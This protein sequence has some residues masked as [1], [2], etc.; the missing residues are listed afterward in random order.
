MANPIQSRNAAQKNAEH[1]FR[2]AEEQPDTSGIRMRTRKRA[3]TVTIACELR[4]LRLAKAT[5][6]AV[7]DKL[8]AEN[9]GAEPGLQRRRAPAARSIL[10]MRY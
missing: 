3:G 2:S 5:A 8:A 4:E 7:A 1:Y 9:A 10:R 6:E